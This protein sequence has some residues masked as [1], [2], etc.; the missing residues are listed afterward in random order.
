MAVGGSALSKVVR[1]ATDPQA[2]RRQ[3]IGR[4]LI[5]LI[6]AIADV[7]QVVLARLAGI[8]NRPGD[9]PIIVF[10]VSAVSGAVVL[11]CL[12]IVN[13]R[14]LRGGH[15]ATR[16][17][18]LRAQARGLT[19]LCG[20]RLVAVIG[21]MIALRAADST[22]DSVSQTTFLGLLVLAT[23]DAAVALVIAARSLAALPPAP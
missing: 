4:M 9:G 23:L 15:N 22:P 16:R 14:S 20:L 18:G 11:V 2:V 10:E 8:G 21:T 12:A 17:R 3:G 19:V 13:A 6:W 1:H 7:S 5:A